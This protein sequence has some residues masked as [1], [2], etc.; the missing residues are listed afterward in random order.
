MTMSHRSAG[1]EPSP[2]RTRGL[3]K[4]FGSVV[5]LEELDLELER[6]EI[7]GLIGP[8]GAGKT[9]TMRLLLDLL[10]PSSGTVEVLGVEPRAG[11]ADLRRRL[12]YLPGEL[13]L[14]GRTSG[15]DL[16][17]H[18]AR[19]SGPVAEGDIDRLA[20]RL[21]VDLDRQT[22]KLSKGNK[23]KLGLIQAFQHRP[24]LLVLDEPTSG[25]DPLVQQE[26]LALIEEAAAGGQTVLLSSH[27]LSEIDRAADRIA[28]LHRGR[29]VRS[30][31]IAELNLDRQRRVQAVLGDESEPAS[32]RL[33]GLLAMGL[34]LTNTDDGTTRLE[35]TVGDVDELVKALAGFEVR[36]LVV[37]RPT[38]EDSILELYRQSGTTEEQRV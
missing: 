25:L 27:V 20:E 10:R 31:S 15:R 18:F 33:K 30:G 4:R 19:L 2:V 23:Q 37:S 22:R 36:D 35:G 21:G 32:E 11:G 38:L 28:V 14:E 13:H 12:G 17:E 34:E 9:T 8:N 16:L 26:F 5:A 7:F 29:L 3:T 24:E 1:G 6:G